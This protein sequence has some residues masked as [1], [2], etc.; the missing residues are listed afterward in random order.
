MRRLLLLF[1]FI[2]IF[3]NHANAALPIGIY[4]GGRIGSNIYNKNYKDTKYSQDNYKYY[5][6]ENSPITGSLNIG[7]RF[8]NLRAELEYLYTYNTATLNYVNMT[9]G[10]SD[11]KNFSSN[12]IMGNIYINFFKFALIKFYLNAGLGYTDFSSNFIDNKDEITYSFGGGVSI[13]AAEVLSLDLGVRYIDMGHV[14][15]FEENYH[16]YNVNLYLGAR[17]GF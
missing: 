14:K 1:L 17:F 12:T 8:L 6:D 11:E 9:N 2:A 7:A 4:M 5:E 16:L 3:K 10:K 15:M 13:S